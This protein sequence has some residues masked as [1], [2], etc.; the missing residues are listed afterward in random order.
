MNHGWNDKTMGEAMELVGDFGVIRGGRP[1]TKW[2]LEDDM[3]RWFLGDGGSENTLLPDAA[4]AA[5]IESACRDE[6]IRRG[7]YLE[8]HKDGEPVFISVAD[9]TFAGDTLADALTAALEGTE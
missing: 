2:Y 9:K 6:L 3:G 7:H 4:A 8:E 1:L 5:L